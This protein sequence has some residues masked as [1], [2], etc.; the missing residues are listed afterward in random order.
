MGQL[1]RSREPARPPA[2][3][4]VQVLSPRCPGEGRGGVAACSSSNSGALPRGLRA[5]LS[6]GA[7][8]RER[9]RAPA[10]C[11]ALQ[12]ALSAPA[13]PP[14]RPG[15]SAQSRLRGWESAAAASNPPLSSLRLRH[16]RS[17]EG[18][19]AARG[20]HCAPKPEGQG[21]RAG[22]EVGEESCGP[23]GGEWGDSERQDRTAPRGFSCAQV[24]SPDRRPLQEE[25]GP[26]A[27][28]WVS[29]EGPK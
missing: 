12:S 11:L 18:S 21:T 7:G 29:G 5:P 6:P 23:G 26:G 2:P 16:A 10:G 20:C 28:A 13:L 14:A 24:T 3:S 25:A 27:D 4:G 19:R 9:V 22:A 15:R 8:G 17:V 1:A